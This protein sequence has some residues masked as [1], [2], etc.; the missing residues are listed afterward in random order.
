MTKRRAM[1]EEDWLDS[2]SAYAMLQYLHQHRR[3]SRVPGGQR[4][5][6]LFRCACC[7]LVWDLFE[8][9]ACRQAVVVSEQFADGAARRGDLA[10][11][12]QSATDAID[13]QFVQA[14]QSA[15]LG[16]AEWRAAHR[17]QAVTTAA[18]WTAASQFDA[19]V[20]HIVI[21]SAAM[22]RWVATQ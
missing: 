11:A 15:P 7:R 14:V 3:I 5:H 18:V 12:H 1:T 8:E 2:P 13:P 6:R 4:R 20:A 16:S 19:R 9:E 10:A 17:R 21:M 22:A